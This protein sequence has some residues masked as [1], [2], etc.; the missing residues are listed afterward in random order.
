LRYQYKTGYAED[1]KRVISYLI[2]D[3]FIM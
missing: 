1:R 2:N 3:I